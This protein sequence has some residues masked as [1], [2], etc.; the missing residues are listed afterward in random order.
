MMHNIDRGKDGI[1]NSRYDSME[2]D[3]RNQLVDTMHIIIAIL[4]VS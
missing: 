3:L 2:I 1:R 4:V